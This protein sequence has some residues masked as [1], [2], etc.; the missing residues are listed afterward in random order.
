MA[1]EEEVLLDQ[2]VDV[3]PMVPVAPMAASS[4]PKPPKM[5]KPF[6]EYCSKQQYTIAQNVNDYYGPDITLKAT[7]QN[8]R[9]N[10]NKPAEFVLDEI[11]NNPDL[12]KEV[13]EFV[14]L[15]KRGGA[16]QPKLVVDPLEPLDCLSMMFKED[17]STN[18]WR[19][20]ILFLGEQGEIYFSVYNFD[21]LFLNETF[22]SRGSF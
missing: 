2:F 16:K 18:N 9:A 1:M 7:K 3:V 4:P 5:S 14:Q 19:V 17:M 21:E 15:K 13:K 20:R 8:L 10:G 6:H 11:A 12:A 22:L